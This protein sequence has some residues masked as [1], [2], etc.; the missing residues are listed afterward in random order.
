MS[1]G[2]RAIPVVGLVYRAETILLP[3]V[4]F[5]SARRHLAHSVSFIFFLLDPSVHQ[6]VL[7]VRLLTV[8][9]TFLGRT[10]S[11]NRRP[12]GFYFG[13]GHEERHGQLTSDLDYSCSM[14]CC[15]G[16]HRAESTYYSLI[17]RLSSC[18]F[19]GTIFFYCLVVTVDIKPLPLFL[20]LLC[21]GR[22]ISWHRKGT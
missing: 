8:C 2:S 15:C 5:A 19:T 16:I 22:T 9:I 7:S 18:V 13:R 17:L 11:W 21:L 1:C 6:S 4:R 10:S 12:L 20:S 3:L 14:G